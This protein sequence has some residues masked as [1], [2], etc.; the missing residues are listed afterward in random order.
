MREKEEVLMPKPDRI[1]SIQ[2]DS[3]PF[4]FDLIIDFGFGRFRI[5]F[6]SE[7]SLI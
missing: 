5:N 7:G 1:N 2:P 4:E 3:F 6:P